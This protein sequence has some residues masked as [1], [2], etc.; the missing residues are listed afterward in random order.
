MIR[1]IV[2]LSSVRFGKADVKICLVKEEATTDGVVFI[3]I[4]FGLSSTT[5]K[6]QSI[7]ILIA[8]ATI[9]VVLV[10]KLRTQYL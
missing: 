4:T 10:V 5:K 7:S 9:L 1:A 8:L 6:E 3:I 2:E